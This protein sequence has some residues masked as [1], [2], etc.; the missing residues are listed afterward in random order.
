MA[1]KSIAGR[2][3][4]SKPPEPKPNTDQ[5]RPQLSG[6]IH[7]EAVRAIQTAFD[8]LYELRG[9]VQ[10]MQNSG[11]SATD[12]SAVGKDNASGS[13]PSV[14]DNINGV[15]IKGPTDSSTLK[16]SDTLRYNSATGE[17]EFGP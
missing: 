6:L 10:N 1:N 9:Q 11:K 3:H 12:A 15:K 5:Y 8:N 14:N 7:P 16:N 2:S 13:K 4:G 17:F